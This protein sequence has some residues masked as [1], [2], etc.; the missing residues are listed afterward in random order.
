MFYSVAGTQV[1]LE[2]G[3][4]RL[5]PFSIAAGPTLR[6]HLIVCRYQMR[7]GKFRRHSNQLQRSISLFATFFNYLNEHFQLLKIFVN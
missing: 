5:K 7:V 3:S 6:Y 4:G 1:R 2:R